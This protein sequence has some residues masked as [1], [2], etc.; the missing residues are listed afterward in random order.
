MEAEFGAGG[1][2]VDQASVRIVVGEA[3]LSSGAYGDVEERRGYRGPRRSG[4]GI[5]RVVAAAG[6]VGDPT[7][8][9]A[10]GHR[11]RH[12]V[13][14]GCVSRELDRPLVRNADSNYASKW[15]ISQNQTCPFAALPAR[16]SA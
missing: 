11:G 3:G 10:V 14:A 12:G 1:V 15:V 9:A 5:H 8:A 13:T 2:A 7:E 6:A 4:A 16:S